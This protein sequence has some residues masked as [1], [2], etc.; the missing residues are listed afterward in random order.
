VD[1]GL[2]WRRRIGVLAA[3]AALFGCSVGEATAD[4]VV[5]AGGDIACAPGSSTT[6]TKCRERYT[7][8]VVVKGGATRALALGDLQYDSASLSNLRNSYDKT[9]GRFKSITSP[10]LGNHEGSGTGYFDYWN[11]VG[12]SN[13]PAGQRGKGYYSFD[14]GAWHLI[15]L[16]SNCSRVSCN[17]GS[18]Q[19]TWLKA[20][21]AAHRTRCALAYWHHPRFSSGHDGDNTFMQDLWKDLYDARVD[22]A[23]VGHSHDYER[24]APKNASGQ[25][26]RTNGIREFVVG[27]GGAFFTGLS[28]PKPN[29][30]V[31]QNN[32]FGV[33]KFTLHSSSYDWRFVP[34]SGKSFTD[35]GSEACRGG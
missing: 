13:G 1:S 9:W 6:S 15:A 24:F 19:E 11:G 23:L 27:T 20:D 21:L 29:S 14:V 26:D 16:N 2:S 35:S 5:Y 18:A 22:I 28:T 30:E 4:P 33:M 12:V 17:K 10:V 7:S 3:T 25:L 8:D 31:R 34:E 32:A